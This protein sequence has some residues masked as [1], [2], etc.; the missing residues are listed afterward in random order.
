M[1]EERTALTGDLDVAGTLIGG[2][3]ESEW[4]TD[5]KTGEDESLPLP[6]PDSRRCGV[7]ELIKGEPL[8]SMRI[9]ASFGVSVLGA[10]LSE[11]E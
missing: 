5:D 7:D 6:L 10:P 8:N 11:Q 9:I 3:T 1:R 2:S 4:N